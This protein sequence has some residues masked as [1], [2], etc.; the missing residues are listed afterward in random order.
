MAWKSA[1]QPLPKEV[2]P[3]VVFDRMFSSLPNSK[4]EQRDAKQK[5]I[6]DFVREDS[7][8]L[9]GKLGVNDVR[10]LDEYLTAL[11]IILAGGGCGTLLTGR[12]IKY[13]NGTPLGNL[14][15]SMADRMAVDM[16]R[17]GDSS[18]TLPGLADG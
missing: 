9:A 1:T 3:K 5:N 8:D 16:N 12:H 18:G 6:L 2:N 10:R 11:P 14:W 4:R 7:K 17:V 15:V 13:R